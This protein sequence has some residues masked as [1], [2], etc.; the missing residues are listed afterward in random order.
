MT[1]T[2]DIPPTAWTRR[3]IIAAGL[4]WN[5]TTFGPTICFMVSEGAEAGKPWGMVMASAHKADNGKRI[6]KC[7][8][9][10]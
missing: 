5:Q 1:L 3:V 9:G 4:K 2:I 8:H 6:F 7:R 10:F